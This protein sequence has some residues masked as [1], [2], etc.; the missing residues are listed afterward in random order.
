MA[1]IHPRLQQDCLPV[2]RFPLCH[3][4]LMRD[5]NYPWFI[6]VPMREQITEIHQLTENDQQQLLKE[7]MCFSR[8]LEDVFQPDKL[9]YQNFYMNLLKKS[10]GT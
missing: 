1:V 10:E 9:N 6:L 2:G 3:L 8:C 4:L 5:A 7:S